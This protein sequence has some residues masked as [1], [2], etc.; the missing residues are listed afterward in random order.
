MTKKGKTVTC[1]PSKHSL[2]RFKTRYSELTGIKFPDDEI[3]MQEMKKVFQK[4]F[5]RSDEYHKQHSSN[6]FYLSSSGVAGVTHN[7][8]VTKDTFV[9]KTYKVIGA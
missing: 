2:F 1:E 7:F 3:A 5:L 8:I 9:I 4:C 6:A